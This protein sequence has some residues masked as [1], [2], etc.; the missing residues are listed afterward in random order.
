M[1]SGQQSPLR[2]SALQ[3]LAQPPTGSAGGAGREVGG[4]P[5]LQDSAPIDAVVV[6]YNSQGHI[7]ACLASLRAN[8][9]LGQ[10]VVVDCASTDA[11]RSMLIEQT[12]LHNNV[13]LVDAGLNLGFGRAVNRGVAATTS[14]YVA[15]FNPDLVADAGS[16]VA[17]G[18][19][20][21][22]DTNLAVVGPLVRNPDGSIYPSARSFPSPGVAA[23]HSLLG[24]FWSENPWSRR[25]RSASGA[26]PDWISGTAML[27]RRDAFEFVGGFDER[28]FMYVEDLDICW[29]LRQHSFEVGI[30]RSV[31]VTHEIGGSTGPKRRRLLVEHHRSA[32]RFAKKSSQGS[33]RVL[34]PIT[35]CVLLV[36]L[37]AA[38]VLPPRA[39]PHLAGIDNLSTRSA[40]SQAG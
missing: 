37:V 4:G 22:A 21:D 25:Y 26:N 7:E 38:L 2:S 9:R 14:A 15:V 29:R 3:S 34:L 36:R 35:A 31:G 12:A 18:A 10:I 17:L 16:L 6:T 1:T 27:F 24:L 5:S 13:T 40:E 33:A 32:W 19:A 23:G 30:V 20:L 28:Y 8:Q 11:T 39:T